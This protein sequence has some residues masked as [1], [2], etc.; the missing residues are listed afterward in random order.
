MKNYKSKEKY[1]RLDNLRKNTLLIILITLKFI[2][3]LKL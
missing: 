2:I 1:R 3:L